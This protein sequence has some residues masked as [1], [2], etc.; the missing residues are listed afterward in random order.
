MDLLDGYKLLQQGAEALTLVE[1]QG[2]CIDLEYCKEKLE[3]LDHKL[4]QSE[5][6]LRR[7]ELGQAWLS[8]YGDAWKHGSPQQLQHILYVD[9]RVK[10]F[11]QSDGGGDSTDAE[12]L[13]QTGV[14]GINH[15]LQ[16]R[17]YKK[18]KDVLSGLVRYSINGKIH[19]SFMLHTVQTYRSSSAEP[20]LQNV[21]VRDKEIMD[22]CRRAF[23][24]SPGNILVEIDFS[25]IEVGIATTY[26]KDPVMIKY[27][28][29]DS[30]DMHAD[31]AG[32]IFQ[33]PKF[34]EPLKSLEGGYSLRQASKNGFVFPEFYGDFFVPCAF[35]IAC[36]W[37][38]LPQQGIWKPSDGIVFN[39]KTM[40]EHLI[41]K[42]IDSLDA[43]TSH[44]E[45]VEKHFWG[46]RFKVYND[47]RKSWY[48]RYQKRGEFEMKTG[49]K[50]SGV[51]SKNQVINYPVQGS[52]FHCLL[53][54]LIQLVKSMKGWK[55]KVIGEIHDS[56]LID[57][58]PDEFVDLIG[59]AQMICTVD[60][61]REWK[62]ITVPMRV[63]VAASEVGGNWSEM[64]AVA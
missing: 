12:S 8:R 41:S 47:W 31:M 6:R 35:N 20:N 28:Q 30:S 57:V 53:W 59:L 14:D 26:H 49:F 24:P 44:M 54:S 33:L 19:P 50:V 34:N 42:D 13:R 17:R 52:A 3:W 38:K 18:A 58:H 32:D 40:G 43:F 11:K 51:L 36:T 27:L 21:P 9:M 55:S 2:I 64:K 39:G 46:V 15:L 4:Q 25:G 10:P 37:C 60:L 16:M 48:A 23:V 22:I 63:E 61:P 56:A 7:S 62:W 5:L 45:K 29:D 1:E